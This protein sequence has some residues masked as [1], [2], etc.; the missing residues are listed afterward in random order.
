MPRE[1]PIYSDFFYD[2][3]TEDVEE[4]LAR[5]QQSDS[6]RYEYFSAAWR[7]MGFSDVFIGIVSMAEQKRFSRV[8]LATAVKYFLPPYSYQ[9]RAGGLYLMFGLYN[10]QLA[11][12]RVPIRLA[13]GDW[14]I[15][16]KFLKDSVNSGHQDVVYIYHK[17]V[18]AKAIHFTA[19]PHFLSFLKLR[20]RKQNNVCAEFIGRS[21][22]VQELFSADILDEVSNIESQYEKLKENTVAVRCEAS[23][24]QRDF[25]A[26]LKDCMAEFLTWQQKTFSQAEADNK[27]GGGDD[28]DD[29]EEEED[30]EERDYK[31]SSSRARLISSIKQ[32]S[33]SN[34]QEAPKA[35]RHR[36][37]EKLK[38]ESS[39]SG[40]EQHYGSGR[41]RRPPSL[42]ARTWKSLGVTKDESRVQVWLLSAPEQKERVPV[43]RTNQTP[44]YKD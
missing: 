33:Y 30:E 14:D 7:Q 22:A 26:R 32:K 12:P 40:S 11:I 41:K 1:R 20:K 44:P 31:A 34:F 23:M 35:R 3:L 5:F 38:V 43:K 18:A 24:T 4:L 6:I 36:Q 21:M 29:D 37:P 8:T 39:S 9:I 17:L 42:R 15:I 13:L 2:P 10:T 25:T 27:G 28:E 16:Q 19:M